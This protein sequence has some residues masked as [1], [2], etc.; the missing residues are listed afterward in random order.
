M[1][2][3]AMRQPV[4]GNSQVRKKVKNLISISESAVKLEALRTLNVDWDSIA[5][6]SP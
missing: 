1:E 2:I 6:A 5:I 3:D 4:T